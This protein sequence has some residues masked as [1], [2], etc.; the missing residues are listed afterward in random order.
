MGASFSAKALRSKSYPIFGIPSGIIA[1]DQDVEHVFAKER[2]SCSAAKSFQPYENP[3][4]KESAVEG[5]VEPQTVV[6][7]K[8][9]TAT[10]TGGT[11]TSCGQLV[12]TNLKLTGGDSIECHPLFYFSTSRFFPKIKCINQPIISLTAQWQDTFFHWVYQVLPR[13]QLVDTSK[14][15]YVDQ[16]KVFQRESLEILGIDNIIDAS[17][18]DAVKAPCVTIPSILKIPTPRSCGY[19]SSLFS[20]HIPKIRR[21][22]LYISRED[23]KTRTILNELDVWEILQKYGYEKVVLSSKP[24]LEQMA[25]FKSAESVVSVHGDELSHLVFCPLDTPVIELFHKNYVN[26]CYWHISEHMQLDYYNIFDLRDDEASDPN[27][28]VDLEALRRTLDR[29]HR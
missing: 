6:H 10:S 14:L 8:N 20:P 7:I 3:L 9:G 13:L 19:I 2:I 28:D 4:F 1:K 29:C 26:V 21:R 12:T 27:I 24:L 17:K 22:R 5:V 16:S 25:L 18:F 11:L 15:L 23:A